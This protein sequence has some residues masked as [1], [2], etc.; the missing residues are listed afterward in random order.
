MVE[1]VLA[2]LSAIIVVLGIVMTVAKNPITSAFSLVALMLTLAGVYAA[3]GA[4]FVAALQAIVYAGA[5][6][7]LFVF[8]IMLLN[9]NEEKSEINLESWRTYAGFWSVVG[10]FLGLA[11]AFFQW[12]GESHGP[13]PGPWSISAIKEH[14]GNVVALS[15]V[16]F[17]EYY[18]QFEVISLL[19]LVAMAGALVLAKRKVD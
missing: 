14:G 4:H 5:V 10:L 18:I 8:S 15:G 11:Y 6:M 7:V 17:S 2:L 9:M 13:R 19:L 12:A 3:I 1:P 16:L